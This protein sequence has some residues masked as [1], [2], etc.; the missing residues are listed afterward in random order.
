MSVDQSRWFVKTKLRKGKSAMHRSVRL[1]TSEIQLLTRRLHILK[2]KRI[3]RLK[4]FL[5]LSI[6]FN[7]FLIFRRIVNNLILPYQ[8]LEQKGTHWGI[9]IFVRCKFAFQISWLEWKHRSLFAS[10]LVLSGIIS[11]FI[12]STKGLFDLSYGKITRFDNLYYPT[13]YLYRI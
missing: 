6:I 9:S 4:A 13:N 8:W 7:K 1:P 11:N 2:K 3:D 10:L 5:P 12:N